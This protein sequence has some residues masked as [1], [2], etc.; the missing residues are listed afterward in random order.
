M[1]FTVELVLADDATV[2]RCC[3]TVSCAEALTLSRA[4]STLLFE[5]A[6]VVLDFSGVDA[7]DSGGLGTL[8]LLQLYVRSSGRSLRYCRL[9]P[10]VS[11]AVNCTRLNAV[12]DIYD[13]QEQA[14]RLTRM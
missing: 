7:V 8:A 13:S 3:G 1:Q 9:K 5:R 4:V 6:M 12:F 14:C 11:D 10:Q 2:L